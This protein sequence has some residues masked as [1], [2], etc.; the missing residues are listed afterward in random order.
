MI[1]TN[2]STLLEY[3]DEDIDEAA[4]SVK[5][6]ISGKLAAYT[7][8]G[9]IGWR[10]GAIILYD[11]IMATNN[12][13]DNIQEDYA[14]EDIITFERAIV[15][16]VNIQ[17][18]DYCGTNTYEVKTSAALSGY[19]PLLYDMALSHIYPNYLTADRSS[20]STKAQKV[21][22]YYF[23]N[24]KDVNKVLIT[25]IYD[26]DL[27]DTCKLP[28]EVWYKYRS[29]GKLISDVETIY[30]D[31]QLAINENENQNVIDQ[32]QSEYLKAKEKAHKYFSQIPI[33]HKYQIK[34]PKGLTALKNNHSRFLQ[35]IPSLIPK[36]KL[37]KGFNIKAAAEENLWNAAEYFF[38]QMYG[39]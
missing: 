31:L 35:R 6:A 39:D 30:H 9:A 36:Q 10:H 1:K 21:W 27:D 12:I 3:L 28:H 7:N 37:Y 25:S 24:R 5:Q 17:P 14:A 26:P 19:G 32:L 8:Q 11:P 2:L 15:G 34:S 4:V 23:Y 33:A 22:E 38:G 29:T 18:N 16:Y 13:K 20:V